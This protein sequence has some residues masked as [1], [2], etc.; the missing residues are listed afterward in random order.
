MVKRSHSL[1]AQSDTLKMA[2]VEVKPPEHCPL[3]PQDV[4]FWNSI[5]SVRC[6]WT[7]VDLIFAANMARCMADIEQAQKQ[8]DLEGP[9]V[10]NQRG[11]QIMNPLFTVIEQLTRRSMSMS[12][13]IQV[14]AAATVGEAKN[15]K[16]KN[17][18]HQNAQAAHEVVEDDDLIAK[19]MMQ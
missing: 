10:E 14:H 4:P 12:S 9:V 16:G 2:F 18:K 19:P 1:D 5:V 13:K 11:T 15:N 7:T 3:R 8:L 17:A 6:N